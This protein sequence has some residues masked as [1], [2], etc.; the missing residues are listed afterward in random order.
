M[1][2]CVYVCDLFSV[3]GEAR[4]HF[5]LVLLHKANHLSERKDARPLFSPRY[6][7]ERGRGPGSQVIL[8]DGG[9]GVKLPYP[10][11][12]SLCK[13][14][15]LKYLHASTAF[16]TIL[17]KKCREPPSGRHFSTSQRLEPMATG[18]RL[19]PLPGTCFGHP[20]LRGRRG[21]ESSPALGEQGVRGCHFNGESAL[22]GKTRG[23]GVKAGGGRVGNG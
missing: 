4:G 19:S 18:N 22:G 3:R 23:C 8:K 16:L 9:G 17:I 11:A 21:R 2:L 14:P 15:I 7:V 10:H 1:C 12:L 6:E 20:H 13:R 5:R